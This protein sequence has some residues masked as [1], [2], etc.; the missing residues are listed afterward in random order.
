MRVFAIFVALLILP[1]TAALSDLT[2]YAEGHYKNQEKAP[3]LVEWFHGEDDEDQLETLVEM[4]RDGE[5]TLLHWRNGAGEEGGGLPGDEADARMMSH[6]TNESPFNQTPAAA[7]DGFAGKI[8]D[9]SPSVNVNEIEIDWNVQLIGS[10]EVELLNI[11]ASWTNP[12]TLN[13]ATQ[14]HVFIIETEAVDSKGR[15]VHN[16]VRDWAT[17]PRYFSLEN[18]TTIEWNQTIT[19]DHLD[20]AGIDLDDASEA[21][22]YEVLLVLVGGFE[23]D[24]SLNRVLS[25]QRAKMPTYWQSV[26]KGASLTPLLLLV[27]LIICIGFVV[28][29][30][31]RRELGLPRLEGSWTSENGV[32]EYRIITGYSV[33][34][35]DLDM[36]GGWKANGR[37]KKQNIAA[38]SIHNGTLRV[39]GSGDLSLRLFVKVDQLGD[40]ILD[41]NLPEPKTND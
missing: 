11:T 17:Q 31:R 39:S 5:I 4:D 12:K 7:I 10:T 8:S 16:L 15:V 38:N 18:N 29:S 6:A 37:I 1:L 28:A 24:T 3:I 41:L 21:N 32:I 23:N 26:D 9:I 34:I 25:I 13:G 2:I 19:R 14:M 36:G 22:K 30:E 33:D 20:G 35:G 27:A 40:W